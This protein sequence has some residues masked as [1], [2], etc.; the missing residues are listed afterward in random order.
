MRLLPGWTVDVTKM[1]ERVP[2]YRQGIDQ[3]HLS[4]STTA[5][6][7]RRRLLQDISL[8]LEQ[9]RH[10]RPSTASWVYMYK[11]DTPL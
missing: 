5:V 11:N 2:R 9:A 7:D 8:E 3:G 6:A 10:V 4:S 1:Y